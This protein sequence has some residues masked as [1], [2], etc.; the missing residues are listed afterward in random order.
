MHK[1]WVLIITA[2]VPISLLFGS[3]IIFRDDVAP[4]A[5]TF[6]PGD[7]TAVLTIRPLRETWQIA[8]PHLELLF[9]G[10]R[11]D[12][13]QAAKDIQLFLRSRCLKITELS[14]FAGLGIDTAQP[15]A[16][17]MSR[18]TQNMV[19]APISDYGK[20]K[21]FLATL[22]AENR[23]LVL[24]PSS[25]V[26]D[27]T[28]FAITQNIV[29]D[30]FLCG[31]DGQYVTSDIVPAVGGKVQLTFVV[32]VP[33][34]TQTSLELSCQAIRADGTT[35]G[36]TCQVNGAA[37]PP[38]PLPPPPPATAPATTSRNQL[39]TT[40]S[41]EERSTLQDP[42]N[43]R[44]TVSAELTFAQNVPQK[45]EWE[46]NNPKTDKIGSLYLLQTELGYVI[47]SDS[48][49]LLK[50]ALETKEEN[51]AAHRRQL[52]R[53]RESGLF[54]PFTSSSNQLQGYISMP[55]LSM[56]PVPIWLKIDKNVVKLAADVG[57]STWSAKILQVLGDPSQDSFQA[58]VIDGAGLAV[59]VK[60]DHLSYIVRYSLDYIEGASDALHRTLGSFDIAVDA[61]AD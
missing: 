8:R 25:G 5:L 30:G 46:I 32:P 27:V 13:G 10:S 1:I 49:F 55:S 15:W 29:G 34:T 6:I 37:Q 18:L 21:R 24:T 3:S 17:G 26:T 51:L 12:L 41:P 7:A 40:N 54:P 39:P 28:G 9:G 58:V 23:E 53:L 47:L 31:G 57:I 35:S 4:A 42:G 59:A 61:I 16:A 60:N 22:Q 45:R 43:P 33:V 48:D 50:S 36:C 56:Y 52:A 44:C 38:P 20:F 11:T 14:D 19:V 2:L